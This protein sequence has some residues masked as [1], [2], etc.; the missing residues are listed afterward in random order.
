MLKLPKEMRR[1]HDTLNNEQAKLETR[2]DELFKWL[3]T[4]NLLKKDHLINLPKE[5]KNSNQEWSL[6]KLDENVLT[7]LLN[8]MKRIYKVENDFGIRKQM[9]EPKHMKNA[10]SNDKQILSRSENIKAL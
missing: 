2:I 6:H 7:V 3:V 5:G 10:P 4:L 1:I 8:F 9:Y